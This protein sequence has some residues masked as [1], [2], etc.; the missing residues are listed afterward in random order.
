MAFDAFLKLDQIDGDSLDKSFLNQIEV[1][2]FDWSLERPDGSPSTPLGNLVIGDLVIQA[3]TGKQTTKIVDR[4]TKNQQITGG[5]LALTEVDNKTGA[6]VKAFGYKMT[7]CLV[8]SY[9][10]QSGG[11]TSSPD[12][13]TFTLRWTELDFT[14]TN[15]ANSVHIDRNTDT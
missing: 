6:R 2:T 1:T 15:T 12:M 14:N 13:E 11:D 3:P 10:L 5:E 8:S 4:L 7:N 9:R